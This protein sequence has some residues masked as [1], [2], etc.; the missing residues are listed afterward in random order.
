MSR[1][2]LDDRVFFNLAN[3]S[4]IL[5]AIYIISACCLLLL[6]FSPIGF[7]RYHSN[8]GK[9]VK[10]ALRLMLNFCSTLF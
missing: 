1:R 9:N 10:S 7:T 4:A 8:L 6:L 2:A 3:I 5:A